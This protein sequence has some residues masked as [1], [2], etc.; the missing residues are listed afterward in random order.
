MYMLRHTYLTD[1]HHTLLHWG[2]DSICCLQQNMCM[3]IKHKS[4]QQYTA[5]LCHLLIRSSHEMSLCH[6][7]HSVH[8]EKYMYMYNVVEQYRFMT[9]MYTSGMNVNESLCIPM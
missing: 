5:S 4:Y 6:Q 3:V 1:V 2:L 9:N 7:K 8:H